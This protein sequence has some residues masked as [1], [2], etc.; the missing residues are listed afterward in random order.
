[1]VDRSVSSPP[2][3]GNRPT[4]WQAPTSE[5]TRITAIPDSGPILAKLRANIRS[6]KLSSDLMLQQIAEAARTLTRAQGV[7][8][9]VR[10][11]NSV[12]CTARA[13]SM[14]PDLG[15]ELSVDSGI[16]GQCFRT[17]EALR[18]D[19][20]S[21]DPRVDAQACRRLGLKSLA[22]APIGTMPA[23]S[24]VLEVFSARPDAFSDN[25][26]RLLAEL[27][28]LV[29]AVERGWTKLDQD[30][31]SFNR[32]RRESSS[33]AHSALVAPPVRETNAAKQGWRKAELVAAVD[34]IQTAL[35]HSSQ[36]LASATREPS[37]ITIIAAASVV[38]AL[39]I[40]LGVRGKAAPS[41]SVPPR[42]QPPSAA[43]AM[44]STAAGEPS[45]VQPE[46]VPSFTVP[47]ASRKGSAA[48]DIVR[49]SATKSRVNASTTKPEPPAVSD[50]QPVA[51]ARSASAKGPAGET[52]GE[53]AIAPPL[54]IVSAGASTV[55][56]DVLTPPNVAVQPE[57]KL[58]QGVSGGTIDRHVDP[59]YP[60]EARW[61][62]IDGQ[63]VLQATITE[64]G[65]VRGLKVIAGNSLLARAA[66]DAVAQWHY[67]PYR[68]NGQPIRMPTQIT[69]IFKLH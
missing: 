21:T 15:S 16:S 45:T 3:L 32:Q 29:M 5:V 40:W 42:T 31:L 34:A 30:E 11:D 66:M 65:N 4:P 57:I 69:L 33:G 14:A 10:Q 63:V 62:N 28:E 37:R 22:V 23:L 51:K 35:I 67:R 24:G 49:A 13:G 27:A 26:V 55:L 38:L 60:A 50:S 46:P 18:C 59:Q 61:L 44:S 17:G 68:L 19:D 58:S 9:A 6:R 43:T 52:R 20:T 12:L 25:D 2:D 53:D 41:N 8:I 36:K 47:A 39:A 48:R 7:A 64:Q 1:M 54:P 56:A